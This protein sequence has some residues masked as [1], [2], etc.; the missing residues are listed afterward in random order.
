[1]TRFKEL[2]RIELAIKNKNQDEIN[3]ALNYCKSRLK[4]ARLKTHIKHWEKLIIKLSDSIG[5]N[6]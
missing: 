4:I 5:L 2:Q 6:K 1:M 3:W